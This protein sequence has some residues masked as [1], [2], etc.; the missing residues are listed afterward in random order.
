MK[1]IE[2]YLKRLNAPPSQLAIDYDDPKKFRFKPPGVKDEETY[3][4]QKGAKPKFKHKTPGVKEE[5]ELILTDQIHQP[6]GKGYDKNIMQSFHPP[7]SRKN[8]EVLKKR[9]E[10]RVQR[11]LH[12]KNRGKAKPIR[13][14]SIRGEE[15]KYTAKNK[16]VKTQWVDPEFTKKHGK[17]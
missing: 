3:K 12:G 14:Y 11:K 4:Y 13:A 7:N 9:A 16:Q 10:R 5:L 17:I 15:P 8:I 1:I 2:Q 6:V